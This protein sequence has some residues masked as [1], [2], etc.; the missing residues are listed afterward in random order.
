MH[1]GYGQPPLAFYL[2]AVEREKASRVWIVF[3][4]RGNPAV[5]AAEAA[6]RSKGIEVRMQ[7]ADL[8]ADLRI[9][10]SAGCLVASTGTFCQGAAALSASLRR[11]YCFGSPPKWIQRLGIEVCAGTDIEGFYRNA[12]MAGNWVASPE[13]IALML[14][15]PERAIAFAEHPPTN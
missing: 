1:R 13:Q 4:D 9:L 11:Y 5:D 7:S 15:Y 10:M 12:A 8:K 2:A 6:L 3:E 14:R